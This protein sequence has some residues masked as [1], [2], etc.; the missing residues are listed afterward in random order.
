MYNIM[1]KTLY[2]IRHGYALHNKLFWDIGSRA[3]AEYRDTPLLEV[4]YNQA[5][6]LNKTWNEIDDIQLVV[7]SPCIRT[8][9]TA[10]FVFQH[11]NV[12]IIAKD[13]LIEYPLGGHE[14]CNKRKNVDDL[15]YMYPYINF[16][17]YDNELKWSNEKET[18]TK[19][20]NRI[21]DMLDW[22]GNRRETRIAIVSHSSFIGQFKDKKIG[23]ENNELIHCYP[24]KIEAIYSSL[25]KF[26]SMKELRA[27]I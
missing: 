3:Y 1:K 27:N 15:R 20:E 13:F 17:I 11:R 7:V 10:T 25:K 6:T 23:D 14:I 5:K 9:D 2:C 24:Y 8:L 12:P 18:I 16:D 19:L 21:E 22:I 26:I 4:G